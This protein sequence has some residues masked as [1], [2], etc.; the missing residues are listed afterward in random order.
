MLFTFLSSSTNS[1]PFLF[2]LMDT[3]NHQNLH[4][5]VDVH[6]DRASSAP[7]VVPRHPIVHASR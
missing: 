5:P 6:L 7:A 4:L 2:L 3:D 1:M